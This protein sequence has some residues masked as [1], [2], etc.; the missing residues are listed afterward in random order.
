[1]LELLSDNQVNLDEEIVV[2]DLL[3]IIDIGITV[4]KNY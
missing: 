1:M 3:I 2:F 4:S